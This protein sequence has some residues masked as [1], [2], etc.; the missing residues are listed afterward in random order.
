MLAGALSYW[1]DVGQLSA[2][3]LKLAYDS[4]AV[5]QQQVSSQ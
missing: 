4:V 1:F 2:V 5:I 3:S